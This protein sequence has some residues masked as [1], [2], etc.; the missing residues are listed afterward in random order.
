MFFSS[1]KKKLPAKNIFEK[2]NGLNLSFMGYFFQNFDRFVCVF[3]VSK[4]LRDFFTGY[5]L[6][7]GLFCP[8]FLQIKNKF[9]GKKS[10]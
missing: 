9:Y 10:A 1:V 7:H 4:V 2:F 3:L 6:L 8:N 5:F